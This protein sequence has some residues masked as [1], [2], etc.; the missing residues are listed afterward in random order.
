MR[1]GD[2]VWYEGAEVTVTNINQMN[3]S[4]P[5]IE[6]QFQNQ[7]FWVNKNEVKTK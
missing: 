1:L 4:V 3:S 7:T 2:K 6:V 5:L